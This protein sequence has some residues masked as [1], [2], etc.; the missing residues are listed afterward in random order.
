MPKY[1]L[2]I[3]SGGPATSPFSWEL[4]REGE[5][6]PREKS[7]ETFRTVLLAKMAGNNVLREL[8]HQGGRAPKKAKR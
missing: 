4:Y 1:R 7:R 6:Y 2:Q 8:E 5:E 3:K